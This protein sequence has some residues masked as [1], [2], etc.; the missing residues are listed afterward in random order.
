MWAELRAIS[1]VRPPQGAIRTRRDGLVGTI[2][3]C[4]SAVMAGLAVLVA[5]AAAVA[6]A[7]T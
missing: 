7:I 3:T 5:A 1:V 2:A 6:F 4:L